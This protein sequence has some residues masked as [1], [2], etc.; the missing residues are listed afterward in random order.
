[1]LCALVAGAVL[2]Q[3]LLWTPI[4]Y[5]NMADIAQN[6]F[7][8]E[9][10]SF[11]GIDKNGNP[12]IFRAKVARQEY[13]HPDKIFMDDVTARTVRLTEGLKVTDNIRADTGIFNRAQQTATLSGNVRVDSD[14]GDTL[15]ANE[16]VIRL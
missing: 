6:Q 2:N 13:D 7:K 9:N 4:R 11:A 8:M 5:I 15:R 3:N 14:N 12:F 16:L 10:P 1:M